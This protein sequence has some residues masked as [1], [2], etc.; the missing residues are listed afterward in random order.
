MQIQKD[1]ELKEKSDFSGAIEFA[2]SENKRLP[3]ENQFL[4]HYA[5]AIILND[6]RNMFKRIELIRFKGFARFH[7]DQFPDNQF[8]AD[9]DHSVSLLWLP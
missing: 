7:E 4:C 5:L 2:L 9:N 6:R 1:P 3:G 8:L